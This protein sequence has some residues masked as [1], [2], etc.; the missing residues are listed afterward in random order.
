MSSGSPFLHW[1]A[2]RGVTNT[3][4]EGYIF[5]SHSHTNNALFCFLLTIKLSK[6]ANIRTQYNELPYLTKET[7]WESDK[8]TRKHH[9]QES[10]EVSPFPLW[11]SLRENLYSGVCEQQKMQTS[12][13]IRAV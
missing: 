5:L 2:C 6:K 1:E 13:R 8:N 7:T 12:L 11:A 10:R 4:H 9:I 3:D